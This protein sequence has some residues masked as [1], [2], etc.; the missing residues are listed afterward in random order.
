MSR[1]ATRSRTTRCVGHRGNLFAANQQTESQTDRGSDTN[2]APGVLTA[3]DVG[4]F[5]ALFGFLYESFLGVGQ[6]FLTFNQTLLD[7]LRRHADL[8]ATL[9][10]GCLAK[11]FPPSTPIF[12]VRDH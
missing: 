11:A 6:G 5:S 7:F 3:I 1:V 12:K 10:G 4:D 9:T 8:I 2:R